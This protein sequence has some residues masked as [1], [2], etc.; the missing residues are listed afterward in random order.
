MDNFSIEAQPYWDGLQRQQLLIQQCTACGTYRHYPQPMCPHCRSTGLAW[1]VVAGT[2]TLHS[3]TITHQTGIPRFAEQVPYVVA[4]VD[5]AE[6]VRV[7][8]PLREV[9][10]ETLRIGLPV[11]LMF[12]RDAEGKNFPAF[13]LAEA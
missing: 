8:A 3:W 2:G 11:R 5:L 9:A 4:T 12:E 10:R 6:G 7:L 1:K 13:V